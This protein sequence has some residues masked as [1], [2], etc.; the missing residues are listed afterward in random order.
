MLRFRHMKTIQ[1]FASVHG[2]V[3]D[4]FSLECQLI[5]LRRTANDAPLHWWSGSSSRARLRPPKTQVHRVRPE[6]RGLRRPQGLAADDARGLPGR[7]LHHRAADARY[8][9]TGRDQGQAGSHDE[10]R[11]GSAVPAGSRQPQVLRA[12][13]EHSVG[14]GFHPGLRRGRLYVASL[15]RASSTSS[16]S[17]IPTPGGSWGGGGLAERRMPASSSMPWSRLSMIAGRPI[18]AVSSITATG[19]RNTCPSSTPSASPKPG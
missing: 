8:G 11:Q 18:G 9:S 6:L 12:S 1:K 19:G 17:S 15:K 2:N 14:V 3:P 5:D 16:S 7:P 4:H 13:V 10:E